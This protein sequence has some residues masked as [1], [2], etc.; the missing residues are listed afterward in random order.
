MSLE[1]CNIAVQTVLSDEMVPAGASLVI[2]TRSLSGSIG[3]AIGQNVYQDS[4]TSRLAG[5]VPES[6][7]DG[8][9]ATT[10]ISS[11]QE[12]IGDN[13]EL[14]ADALDRVND[15]LTRTFLVALILSCL[16]LPA[17]LVIEWKSVKKENRANEDA[18]E[19]SGRKKKKKKNN[20]KKESVPEGGDQV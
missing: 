17:G 4:L 11:I 16:T 19:K 20:N 18:K 9:G 5:I 13:A 3:S 1:Q 10:L 12:A 6:A 14:Y 7:L 15:S 2:F 8:S